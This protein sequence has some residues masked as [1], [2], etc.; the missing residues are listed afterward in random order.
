MRPIL[1][2]IGISFEMLFKIKWMIYR[3]LFAFFA[4]SAVL[5]GGLTAY[6]LGPL[7]SWYFFSDLNCTKYYKYIHPVM[8]AFLRYVCRGFR[9]SEYRKEF[10]V[11]LFDPPLVSPSADALRIKKSWQGPVEN[12]DG[13]AD[14]CKRIRC[15][16]L[17][18]QS[19]HCLSYGS[20][21]W[22]FFSCGRYPVNR[23]QAA[24]YECPKWEFGE[25]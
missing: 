15:P 22:R 5:T 1:W 10:S 3:S 18:A 20:F 7:F 13:C 21:Y 24:Y 19:N 25:S 9:D 16:L 14:C 11:S 12:C 2:G 6:A 23:F 4:M 8:A 17:D